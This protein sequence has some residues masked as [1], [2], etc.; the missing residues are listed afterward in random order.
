MAVMPESEA[1]ESV[2]SV[3]EHMPASEPRANKAVSTRCEYAATGHHASAKMHAAAHMHTTAAKM[4][5][6]AVEST[7]MEPAAAAAESYRRR[8]SNERRAHRRRGETSEYF[9]VHDS[10]PPSARRADQRP[11]VAMSHQTKII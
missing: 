1:V 6:A 7:T 11:K 3:D 9:A 8:C 2:E 10:D 4:H 5:S